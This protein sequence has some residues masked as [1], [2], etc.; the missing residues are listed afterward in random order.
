VRD[1]ACGRA[2]RR[3]GST[4]SWIEGAT[5]VLVPGC[6]GCRRAR[7]PETQMSP[8][9]EAH[10]GRRPA[11]AGSIGG[12]E[13]GL[14]IGSDKVAVEAANTAQGCRPEAPQARSEAR[15][16][17]GTQAHSPSSNDRALGPV[18]DYEGKIT[19]IQGP[20]KTLAQKNDQP[21]CLGDRDSGF[22]Y[23]D[24]TP[25]HLDS[26][27]VANKCARGRQA[28]YPRGFGKADG[29]SFLGPQIGS[30]GPQNGRGKPFAM[31]ARTR[32]LV[33]GLREPLTSS[34][35]ALIRVQDA[36]A[37]PPRSAGGD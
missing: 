35:I 9:D 1:Q 28:P 10:P 37:V 30:A 23:R 36:S 29:K 12:A 19:L 21:R 14:R 26:L 27:F 16:R 32:P 34:S 17:R 4:T 20:F 25:R 8:G 2:A 11:A 13:S 31:Q 18:A 33:H 6:I 22:C 24:G 7:L 15:T 5:A 3:I